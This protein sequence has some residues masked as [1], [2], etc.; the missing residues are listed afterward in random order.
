MKQRRETQRQQQEVFDDF[1][2]IIS[3]F[4]LVLMFAL[5]YIMRERMIC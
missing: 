1:G 5:H 4:L 2:L 3:L